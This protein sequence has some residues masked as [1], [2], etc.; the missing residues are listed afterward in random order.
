M[1]SEVS[2]RDHKLSS[3]IKEPPSTL[4]TEGD[5]VAPNVFVP[6]PWESYPHKQTTT[7]LPGF[8]VIPWLDETH[9]PIRGTMPGTYV[10]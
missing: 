1:L 8:E 10:F 9:E 2:Y 5:T 7:K 4:A 6:S 3:K